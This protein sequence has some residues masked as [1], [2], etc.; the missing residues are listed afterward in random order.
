[1]GIVVH[2]SDRVGPRPPSGTRRG[3]RAQDP[4]SSTGPDVLETCAELIASTI[5]GRIWELGGTDLDVRH[6]ATS[7]AYAVFVSSAWPLQ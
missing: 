4:G 1:M 5:A 2:L 7:A 6:L 3:R